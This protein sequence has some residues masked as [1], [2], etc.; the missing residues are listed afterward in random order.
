ML[1]SRA[2]RTCPS[3]SCISCN[4]GHTPNKHHREGQ[5]TC[6]GQLKQRVSEN[7]SIRE[8]VEK[9]PPAGTCARSS[10]SEGLPLCHVIT[11]GSSR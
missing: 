2:A 11:L 4:A 5:R 8:S 1:F 9:Q 7:L 10:C 3:I 6:E